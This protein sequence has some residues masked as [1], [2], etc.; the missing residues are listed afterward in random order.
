MD[1]VDISSET[2]IEVLLSRLDY[3]LGEIE[4]RAG[5]E[6]RYFEWATTVL[7]AVFAVVIALADRTTSLPRPLAI[8]LVSTLLITIPAVVSSY[9][10]L[11][12]TSRCV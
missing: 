11:L 1:I 6:T 3:H 4:N 8:K 2:K 12:Y 10:C 5:T 9:R 7:L